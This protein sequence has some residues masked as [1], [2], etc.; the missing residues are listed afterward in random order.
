MLRKISTYGRHLGLLGAAIAVVSLGCSGDN[1]MAA[2]TETAAVSPAAK[3]T[4]HDTPEDCEK[5]RSTLVK[6]IE[7][8]RGL[9][10]R[11]PVLARVYN[12]QIERL[13]QDLTA[14]DEHCSQPGED[15]AAG[16]EDGVNAD[17][18]RKCEQ[19]RSAL[20]SRVD[21]LRDLRD[22][23]PVL[24]RT[25][26]PQIERIEADLAE[27]E[28]RCGPPPPPDEDDG[29]PG[30]RD[31]HGDE[32]DG[33]DE[34]DSRDTDNQGRNCEQR[35]DSL[36]KQIERL[37]NLRE[38]FPILARVYNPQIERLEEDMAELKQ[39]CGADEA[40]RKCEQEL[41]ALK[42]EIKRLQD[43]KERFPVLART[44]DPKV[45]RLR[46]TLARM[47]DRCHQRGGDSAAEDDDAAEDDVA[48]EDDDG[49]D[50]DDESR[51]D[52][53]AGTD[54]EAREDDGGDDTDDEAKED[55]GGDDT[56]DESSD[57]DDGDDTDDEVDDA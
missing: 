2:D 19:E 38:R 18:R 11:F 9:R 37:R 49:N 16:G 8:L 24:A 43:L 36:V 1:P 47:E 15:P 57:D 55:D 13:E 41:K 10:E 31:E 7:R 42:K 53:G 23:F 3:L 25:Y 34:D 26:N 6:K 4:S 40:A 14:L 48:A 30:D 21:R 32:D 44:Y 54:G 56:D 51:D 45:E 27:L 46:E 52:D 39:N 29:D 20:Q 28:E 50:T 33:R 5:Q 35:H 12:P 22:R 17:Q